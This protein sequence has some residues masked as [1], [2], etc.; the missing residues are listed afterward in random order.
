MADS[1]MVA[2]QAES[3][4]VERR[5]RS[6]IVFFIFAPRLSAMRYVVLNK[7]TGFYRIAWVNACYV[8]CFISRN[9]PAFT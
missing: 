4:K 9:I 5:S 1:E 2:L 3:N 8:G 7:T 6:T